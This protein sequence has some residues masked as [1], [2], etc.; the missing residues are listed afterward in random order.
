MLLHQFWL[1]RTVPVA[2]RLEFESTAGAF[3]RFLG[4]AVAAVASDV[5]GQVGIQLAFQC[6]LG[7]L[8]HQRRQNAVLAGNRLPGLNRFQRLFKIESL[9]HLPIPFPQD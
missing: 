9:A 7:Q 2:R 1:E 8:L 4:F 3:H 5:F 6:R